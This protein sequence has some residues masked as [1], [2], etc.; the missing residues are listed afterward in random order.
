MRFASVFLFAKGKYHE[1]EF[2][3]YQVIGRCHKIA[4]TDYVGLNYF[5]RADSIMGETYSVKRLDA[6]EAKVLRQQ[7]LDQTFPSIADHG[8]INLL[9]TCLYHG[10]L[11]NKFLSGEQK[12]SLV[13]YLKSIIKQNALPHSAMKNLPTTHSLW[14]QLSRSCFSLTCCLRNIFKIGL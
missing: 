11:A 2:W 9:F 3:S 4:V 13:S 7:Y 10:Q 5:Q 8:R 1:D 14:L 12:K 6:V